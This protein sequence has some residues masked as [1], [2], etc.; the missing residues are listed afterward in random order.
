[1]DMQIPKIT[2][3]K[4]YTFHKL[5]SLASISISIPIENDNSSFVVIVEG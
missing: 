1:M 4:K 2:I 5:L 3:R